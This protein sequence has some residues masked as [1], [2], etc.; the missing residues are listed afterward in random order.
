MDI[1]LL[2]LLSVLS[3]LLGACP[4]SVWIGKLALKTDIRLYGDG[5]PGAYN[6]FRAGGRFWGVVCMLADILKG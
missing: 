1:A 6:V 4:F 2:I 3:F 5:N